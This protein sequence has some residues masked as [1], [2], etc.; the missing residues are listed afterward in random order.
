LIFVY[1]LYLIGVNSWIVDFKHF[2]ISL[3]YILIFTLNIV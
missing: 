2:D 3:E 1:I